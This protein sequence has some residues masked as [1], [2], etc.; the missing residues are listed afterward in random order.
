LQRRGFLKIGGAAGLAALAGRHLGIA[1]TAVDSHIEVLVEEPIAT[2][3]P[4]IYGHFTEH[5]GAVIYDGVWVGKNSSIPNTGGIRQA[6]IDKLHEI[7]APVIRWPGGCFADSYD[8]RDGVG[9]DRPRR[10]NFWVDDFDPSLLSSKAAALYEPNTFG[11]D[12]FLRFCK[13]AGAEPYVAANVRSLSSLEF[14]HWVEYCNSPAGSTSLADLRAKGGSVEPYNVKLWGIGNESWG[15]GGDFTPQ[16][17]ATEFRRFTAWVPHYGLPLEYV[18]SGPSDDDLNWTRGFFE[19]TFSMGDHKLSHW[20]IHHYAWNLSRGKSNDWTAAKGDALQFDLVDWY[21]IFK[22]GYLVE[23]IIEDQWAAIGEYDHEHTIK[24]VIDEYGPWYKKGTE[25]S[26][27]ALLGQQVTMRDALFTAFTLDVFNR[28]ADKVSIAAC[29]QLINNLNALF[30]AHEDK[31]VVTPNFHVFAMYAAHQG[32]QALRTQ[33]S[34]PEARYMR[35]GKAA[36]FWGLNGSASLKNKTLTLTVVNADA[37]GPRETEIVL[38]GANVDTASAHVLSSADIH[39]HNSFEP[40]QIASPVEA[41]VQNAGS[42]LHFTFPAAS[43]TAIT[44]HLS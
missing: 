4:R 35:D 39:A 44:I 15:C 13:L 43:V 26:P 42:T 2:I 22:Q 30:L 21:E 14:D 32:A 31:F 17:Y 8:W 36:T 9:S 11:T 5:I 20:S 25:S 28:H 29:A 27:L 18:A 23:S 40:S 7:H 24:L 38:R 10:T 33:F 34:S 3:S 1:A 16:D 41:Q 37:S 19:K 6:L 12:E